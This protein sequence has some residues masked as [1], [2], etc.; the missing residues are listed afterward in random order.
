MK[1]AAATV[2]NRDPR[3]GRGQ[4]QSCSSCGPHGKWLFHHSG[5]WSKLRERKTMT[6]R[7]RIEALYRGPGQL[8]DRQLQ[9]L[10]SSM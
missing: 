9:C 8:L 3:P 5:K 6:K 7:M 1:L 4:R 2:A 10:I